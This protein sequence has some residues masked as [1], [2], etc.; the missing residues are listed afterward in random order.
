MTEAEWLACG[1]P[2]EMIDHLNERF[3]AKKKGKR[4]ARQSL[5]RKKRLFCCGGC[6]LMWDLITAE[7]ARRAVE[8]SERFADG[9]ATEAE[10]QKVE[11]QFEH[12]RGRSATESLMFVLA[13]WTVWSDGRGNH[14]TGAIYFCDPAAEYLAHQAARRKGRAWEKAKTAGLAQLSN[15][16]R[17]TFENPFRP[18]TFSPQWRTDTVVSL[19]RQMYES[20]DFS[21]LPILADALQDAGCAS[22]AILDHCRG[23]GPHVRGCWVVDRVL[24]NE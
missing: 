6:R 20:R 1:E 16:L 14:D 10:C 8:V 11:E 18:V 4:A 24:G 15:L 9:E 21:A 7:Q 22:A 2:G 5:V 19:A 12:L 3:H 13:F 17:D 23:S